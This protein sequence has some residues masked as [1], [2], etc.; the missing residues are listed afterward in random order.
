VAPLTKHAEMSHLDSQLLDWYENLPSILKDHEPCSESILNTRT[1]MRWRYY[2]QRML[3]YRPTLLS[4]AMRRVPYIALRSEERTAIERC[5]EIADATIQDIS[6]TAQSHQ[7]SGWNATWLIYQATMVPLLGLFLNDATASDP[8]ASVQSCQSQVETAMMVL[9]RLQLW[10]PTAKRT[11]EAVSRILEA[12]KRG[13]DMGA[14]GLAS[15]SCAHGRDGIMSG[16]MPGMVSAQ[17]EPGRG[18]A[19]AN[20]GGMVDPM[21]P[22]FM[23]DTAGQQLWDFLSWSDPTILSGFSE[24]ENPNE[25]SFVQDEKH[26]KYGGNAPGFYGSPM[27]DSTYYM[28]PSVPFYSLAQP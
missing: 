13:S 7:M 3:L 17:T 24:I 21:A 20:D 9:A 11:L 8:R 2:N 28:H 16:M 14:G 26:M 23:D 25:M 5:R 12:S 22:P 4:Y 6:S 10:S 15:G 19:I 18:V 1:V 27:T